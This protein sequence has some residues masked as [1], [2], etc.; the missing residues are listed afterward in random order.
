MQPI[1]SVLRA[2]FL[3]RVPLVNFSCVQ[4]TPHGHVLILACMSQ[5]ITP[6]ELRA[7]GFFGSV[8][9]CLE[10]AKRWQ[11]LIA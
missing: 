8:F 4:M 3:R 10:I 11:V 2:L 9:P 5:H 7:L 6:R 1:P